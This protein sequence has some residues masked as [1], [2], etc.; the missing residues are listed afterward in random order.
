MSRN[1]G[2]QMIGGPGDGRVV[3]N[4]TTEHEER[5]YL[6]TDGRFMHEYELDGDRLVY[7]GIAEPD[8]EVVDFDRDI[9]PQLASVLQVALS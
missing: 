5:P 4:V 1:E 6:A 9:A 2:W 7:L 8:A 3:Y